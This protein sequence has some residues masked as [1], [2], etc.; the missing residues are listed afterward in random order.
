MFAISFATLVRVG[1]FPNPDT[2]FAHTRLTLS[3]IYL[4]RGRVHYCSNT[5]G[6]NCLR[7]FAHTVHPYVAQHGTDTFRVTTAGVR[8]TR[9]T[10]RCLSSWR[11]F[12]AL[13]RLRDCFSSRCPKWSACHRGGPG[14]YSLSQIQ[15]HC[16]MPCMAH[17]TFTSTGN[18]YEVSKYYPPPAFQ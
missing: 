7:L 1:H 3:F 17:V 10:C 11:F 16:L 5:Y 15:A 8:R 12:R 9:C 14:T 2:L 6:S 13:G 18:C 4:S